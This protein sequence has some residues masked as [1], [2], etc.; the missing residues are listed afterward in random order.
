M[1]PNELLNVANWCVWNYEKRGDAVTKVPYSPI[2]GRKAKSND[3]KTWGSHSQALQ[4][5]S[6]LKADGLGFFLEPPYVGI[7]IDDVSTD[8]ERLKYGDIT[9]NIVFEMINATKSYSEI[10]PSGN[11]VHIILKGDMPTGRRRHK[12]VEMYGSGRYFTMTGNR[13]GN[14]DIINEVDELTLNR[15]HKKYIQPDEKTKQKRI[16]HHGIKHVLSTNEIVAEML[17][18]KNGD[19]IK[20]FLNGGWE[21]DYASQSEADMAFANHLAFWTAKDFSKMDEIFRQSD[22]MRDKWDSKRGKVTYGIETLNKAI[23]DTADIYTPRREKPKYNLMFAGKEE[24][25]KLP[26]RSR[27][28]LGNSQRFTDRYGDIVRYSYISNKFYVY[29]DTKWAEDDRGMVD[30]MI[31][32]TV[33]DMKNE[34]LFIAPDVDE[35]EAEKEWRKFIKQS[36]SHRSMKNMKEVAK[37]EIAVLPETFDQDKMAFNTVN[38][39]VDL[40]SG[41][42][43]DHD[44]EKYFSK[45]AKAEYTD[46]M[47][48]PIWES[49]LEDIFDGDKDVIRYIQ[50]AIGYSLTGSTAEQVMFFLHGRG[51][52]GKSLFVETIAEILGDYS[53]NLR[54]SSLMIKKGD[55]VGNDIARLKGNR[56]VTSS[57]PNEGFV[58]DEGLIKELTGGE[59][60]TV[61][62]L[63]QEDFE[64]EPEFKLWLTTNH[65]PIIKGTDDGIW[66]RV[67]LVPFDVQ[68]PK[69]K[70]DKKL[71][72]KLLKEAPGILDWALEGCMMWQREG[73]EM[74]YAIKKASQEYR[75]DMDLLDGFIYDEC[76]AGSEYEV[77]GKELYQVYKRWAMENGEYEMTNTKF[78]REI[79]KK[80]EK[81]RKRDGVYYQGIKIKEAYPG[82][83]KLNQ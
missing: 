32:A 71:K 42:F 76:E 34:T 74:P 50:K 47:Q 21:K 3:P 53:S 82:L 46:T 55:D 65:K 39:Y 14:I 68:I 80:L 15:L 2:T 36:R 63:Y 13:I 57:E 23:N 30:R 61:R 62:F 12:N 73:L 19:Q 25:K 52:N 83:N 75:R 48:A 26:N 67:V 78:G 49:F 51:R 77:R 5:L 59:K 17:N 11:G 69:H 27:D 33:E 58:L 40:N 45:I 64:L 16:S 70:V 4:A 18:S 44:R 22:L 29:D 28:D 81:S 54:A 41:A 24:E 8:I 43:Y 60:I 9:E 66:R 56:F 38:G 31:T 7:D 1:I 35:E 6:Q 37:Q 20:R 79:S 72:Y 10:S